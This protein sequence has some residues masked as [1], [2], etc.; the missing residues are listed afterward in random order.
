MHRPYNISYP[1]LEGNKNKWNPQCAISPFSCYFPSLKSKT[2]FQIPIDSSPSSP[3]ETKFDT[4]IQQQ[5]RLHFTRSCTGH[6]VKHSLLNFIHFH[7]TKPEQSIILVTLNNAWRHHNLYRSNP[8]AMPVF[9]F[10]H[11]PFS[12]YYL[13]LYS[14]ISFT[15]SFKSKEKDFLRLLIL[16]AFRMRGR[17]WNPAANPIILY[18]SVYCT[19]KRTDKQTHNSQSLWFASFTPCKRHNSV[20]PAY[21]RKFTWN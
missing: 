12:S 20:F 8:V 3:S 9:V 18:F 1:D 5:K 7:N 10:N 21:S 4:H 6:I 17:G 19:K 13:L 2:S 14:T 11:Y 15:P 16:L